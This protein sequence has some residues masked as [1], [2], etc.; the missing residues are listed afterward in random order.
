MS[1][2]W[3]KRKHFYF[4]S[5]DR[6]RRNCQILI[7]LAWQPR[8]LLFPACLW[9]HRCSLMLEVCSGNSGP[10]LPVYIRIFQ[11]SGQQS[12]LT[13]TAKLL[14]CF[15]PLLICS[16]LIFPLWVNNSEVSVVGV[17]RPVK[18]LGVT[19][20][21]SFGWQV[22]CPIWWLFSSCWWRYGGPNL[23]LVSY[24]RHNWFLA[25]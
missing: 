2:I 24:L 13:S 20:W 11:T 10:F 4:E 3:T 1:Y 25:V 5:P 22:T 21:I 12:R 8:H 14:A 17:W 7:E 6:K 18:T 15:F 19:V 16:E 23:V 9:N